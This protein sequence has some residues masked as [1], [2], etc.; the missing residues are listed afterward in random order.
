[1]GAF[2]ADHEDADHAVAEALDLIR[3]GL[4]R[5]AD[6]VL[7]HAVHAGAAPSTLLIRAVE[8]TGGTL[9]GGPT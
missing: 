2:P 9:T 1:M 3:A 4:M 8:R 7:R 5:E 6:L